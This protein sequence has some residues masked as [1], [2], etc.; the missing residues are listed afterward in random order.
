MTIKEV[1]EKLEQLVQEGI[2]ENT[3]VVYYDSDSS[4]M[5]KYCS[6][7]TITFEPFSNQIEIY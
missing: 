1:R 3:E 4:F 7:E 5:S 2:N 6:I